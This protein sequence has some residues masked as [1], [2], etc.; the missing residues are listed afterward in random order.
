MGEGIGPAGSGSVRGR[1]VRVLDPRAGFEHGFILTTHE[2]S[3]RRR[4]QIVLPVLDRVVET[5]EGQEELEI[6]PWDVLPDRRDWFD[7]VP[8]AEPLLETAGL[9][10]LTEEWREG[11]DPRTWLKQQIEVLDTTIDANTLAMVEA[12]ISARLAV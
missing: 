3:R 4:F 9:I 12:R 5:N 2:Y 10:S 8:C 1:L 11:R 6:T 7:R